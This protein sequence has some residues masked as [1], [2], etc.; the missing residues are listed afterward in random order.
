MTK[1]IFAV[2]KYSSIEAATEAVAQERPNTSLGS[3]QE[4]IKQNLNERKKVFDCLW[5]DENPVEKI[6][7][8]QEE[9]EELQ[10]QA[11]AYEGESESQIK[12]MGDELEDLHGYLKDLIFPPD[13]HAYKL[14]HDRLTQHLRQL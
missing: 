2:R 9:L 10:Q 3:I 5:T 14:A 6:N 7:E 13:N 8:L 1:P 4:C 12:S 11:E